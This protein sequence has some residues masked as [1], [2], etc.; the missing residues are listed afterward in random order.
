[1]RR[2]GGSKVFGLEDSEICLASSIDIILGV[3]ADGSK[4]QTSSRAG[5]MG[6][7]FPTAFMQISTGMRF[8]IS[9]PPGSGFMI[10]CNR[11]AF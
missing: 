5:R 2:G 7:L 6:N 11:S 9:G 10:C 3:H 8:L 4:S 1:M